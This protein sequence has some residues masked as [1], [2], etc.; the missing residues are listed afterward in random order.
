MRR[1]RFHLAELERAVD[2]R[3]G[4][5][6]RTAL[7]KYRREFPQDAQHVQEGYELLADCLLKPSRLTS[8]A[9]RRF[10]AAHHGSSLRR[11]IRRVCFE[12]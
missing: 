9:A 4:E 5:A 11:W 8:G 6:L 7:E 1:E 3:D 2:L 10:Y 12:A